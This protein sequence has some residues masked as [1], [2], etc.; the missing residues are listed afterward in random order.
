MSRK[1]ITIEVLAGMVKR[2][3]DETARK[4]D[5]DARFDAVDKELASVK[6]DIKRLEKEIADLRE[7]MA[8]VNKLPASLERRVERMED[9]LRLIKTKIGIR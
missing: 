2:G 5:M 8:F 3:F 9:D 6:S 7:D 1:S 4:A